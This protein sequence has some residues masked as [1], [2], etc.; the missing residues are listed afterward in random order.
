MER[1]SQQT[2]AE[3]THAARMQNNYGEDEIIE[4]TASTNLAQQNIGRNQIVLK[5]P[6][7]TI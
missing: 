2:R 4:Q 7:Q 1:L 5:V 6:T 3:F